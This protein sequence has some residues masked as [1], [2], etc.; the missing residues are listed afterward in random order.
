M[1]SG[2]TKLELEAYLFTNNPDIVAFQE[3]KIDA[4]V[5]TNELIPDTLGYD[6]YRKYRTGFGGGTMLLF[7]TYI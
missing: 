7:K 5:K 1:A 6:V 2:V 4:S 3:T